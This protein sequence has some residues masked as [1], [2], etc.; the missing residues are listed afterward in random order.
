MI[1]D[2]MEKKT[3]NFIQIRIPSNRDNKNK[4]A[5]PE[6]H[7]K[8]K[9]MYVSYKHAHENSHSYLENRVV[10]EPCKQRTACISFRVVSKLS[11]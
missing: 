8:D 10:R 2:K 5:R 6:I 4:F 7:E 11:Y 9:E 1:Q 3:Y